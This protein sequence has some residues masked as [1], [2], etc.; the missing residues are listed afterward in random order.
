MDMGL[1]LIWDG[2]SS[3]LNSPLSHSLALPHSD[4][5]NGKCAALL[6]TLITKRKIRF[7]IRLN[8]RLFHLL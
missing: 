8:E 2:Y 5:D 6:L 1:A 7:F 4:V 3:E